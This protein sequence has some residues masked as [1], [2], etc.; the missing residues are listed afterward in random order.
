MTMQEDMLSI[1]QY[2]SPKKVL[3][4]FQTHKPEKWINKSLPQ[5][6]VCVYQ[7][8]LLLKIDVIETTKWLVDRGFEADIGK[9]KAG[10]QA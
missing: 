6:M 3:A 10:C 7:A 5:I 4:Y 1:M 2:P 8:R 9:I